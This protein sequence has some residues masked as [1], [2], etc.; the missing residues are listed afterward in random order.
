MWLKDQKERYLKLTLA[1]YRVTDLFPEREGLRQQIRGSANKIL[2]DLIWSNPHLRVEEICREI[3]ALKGF[4]DQA[5]EK[6]LVDPRNF[7]VLKREYENILN[8]VQNSRVS[9]NQTDL[10]STGKTVPARQSPDGSRP[11]AGGEKSF[12]KPKS[13]RRARSRKEKVL[14]IINKKERVKVKELMGAFPQVSRRTLLRDLEELYRGGVIIRTG[15]GRG[16]S[17]SIKL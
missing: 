14:E 13:E 10:F 1:V 15:S 2:A 5:Q 16:A 11:L 4:F 17:Y 3:E 6:E 8:Y 12:S 7:A 9:E